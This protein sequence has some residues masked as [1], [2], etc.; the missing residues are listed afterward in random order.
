MEESGD[1]HVKNSLWLYW[2][3]FSG[4]PLTNTAAEAPTVT[5]NNIVYTLDVQTQT[6]SVTESHVLLPEGN[7]ISLQRWTVS[8]R[9]FMR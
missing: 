7:L 2:M 9:R 8:R 5:L 6:A 1:D 4:R 3:L